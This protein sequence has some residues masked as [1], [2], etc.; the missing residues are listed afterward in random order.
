MSEYEC[1]AGQR[2]ETDAAAGPQG[3]AAAVRAGRGMRRAV[4]IVLGYLPV[5]FAF[6]VLADK[7]GLSPLEAVFMSTAVF[8]GS[9]QLIAV[10][11]L[12]TAAGAGAAMFS[13]VLTTFVVNL[14]HLLMAASLAPYL[15]RWSR[16]MQALFA[17]QLTDETF[18]MHAVHFQSSKAGNGVAALQSEYVPDKAETLGL[19]MTAQLGWVA[20]SALG[21]L[22]GGLIGDVK[23]LGLDYALPAMFVALLVAQVRGR[24]HVV[25]AVTSAA[26]SVGLAYAGAG[27]WNVILATVFA[28]TLGT[29][30]SGRG[31]GPV[32]SQRRSAEPAAGP[33]GTASAVQTRGAARDC[34][35]HMSASEE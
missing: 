9:A 6:G 1:A 4:P 19:N 23:P 7:T 33:A 2:A 29:V 14:R 35:E 17:F 24:L 15:R 31:G 3:A 5:G 32:V 11:M 12:A 27:Q 25:V 21:A 26:V 8:A 16:P 18:A 28:A 13:V 30:L 34:A 20:G 10:G 22:F